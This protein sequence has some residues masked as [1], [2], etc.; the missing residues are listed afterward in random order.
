MRKQDL[1]P[2]IFTRLIGVPTN[3]G[4]PFEDLSLLVN[5]T[6]HLWVV[7]QAVLDSHIA[8]DNNIMSF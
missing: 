2:S 8:Y 3:G 5:V 1:Q 7:P 6:C 4:G